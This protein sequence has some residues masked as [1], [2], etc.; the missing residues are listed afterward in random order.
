M[1][2]TKCGN[3]LRGGDRFCGM[4]GTP[5]EKKASSNTVVHNIV[6]GN[7]PNNSLV[8]KKSNNSDKKKKYNIFIYA[9]AALLCIL[10]Y[11]ANNNHDG[12][13]EESNYSEISNGNTENSAEDKRKNEL[14]IFRHYTGS[15]SVDIIERDSYS[16]MSR[17]IGKTVIQLNYDGSSVMTNYELVGITNWRE[18]TKLR[19]QSFCIMDDEIWL[20]NNGST[21]SGAAKIVMDGRDLRNQRGDLFKREY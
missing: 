11:F 21:M 3:E 9:C 2:C 13:Y 18:S 15:W 5:V 7:E 19:F 8:G 6:E 16:G 20:V 14:E 4:C 17:I 12:D 1:I 10:I